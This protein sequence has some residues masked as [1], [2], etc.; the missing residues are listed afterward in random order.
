[1]DDERHGR[2]T[3]REL[4][5]A[6][7]AGAGA[8]GVSGLLADPLVAAALAAAPRCGRLSD[9]EH[10]VILVQENR[11]FDH[12]FGSYRGVAGFQDP[13]A[14]P[15]VF[16][17][18]GYPVA[19]YGGVLQPFH[20][21]SKNGGECTNDINHSWGPQHTYWD[22]GRLDGFV[23]GHVAVDGVATGAL[24]MGY[25]TRADLEFYYALADAF[26][27]CDHYHCSVI[28]PTDPN[29]LYTMSAS[30]GADGTSGGP[31]LSTS[32][33]RLER[34][35]KLSWTTMPEQLEARGVSW[36]VYSTPDGNFGDN[37]LP[38]FKQYQANG[39]LA[40]K[41]LLPS[42][43]GTFELDCL[44]GRLPQVSWVLAPLLLSEHPPTP[45]EWGQYASAQVLKAL[46]GNPSVWAKTAL[47]I[48]FDENGG[49]FDHVPPPAAPAG[50]PGEYLTVSPLPT[51]ASGVAG[52]IGLG[53][54][55]PMLIASPFARGGLVCSDIF[56]HTSTLRFL[57]SRFGTEV[58]NLSAW[59]R[60]VTGDLT[61]AFNFAAVDRSVPS[62][63][64][65]SLADPRVV[66]AACLVGAPAG[67][68]E[69][70][71]ATLGQV[72]GSLAPAYPIPP[73]GGI[74][75]QEPGTAPAPS[76]PV[77]GCRAGARSPRRA[78]R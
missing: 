19:G 35:G 37:V 38:Y 73:N 12:Y 5:R 25:Y 69:D 32:T 27:I 42:F 1:M 36:K 58:P 72:V 29:R 2:L 28:G 50:T 26:T 74:P 31:I 39:T 55:V 66:S 17:Q 64:K 68:L 41:A 15:A 60:S 20:I 40:A 75:H 34:F 71:D 57:E 7:G 61:S 24:A 8:L 56:D 76:G 70:V 53:F 13:Q 43:P 23:S 59:R 45:I 30:L 22:D 49:F 16:S 10:V 3:R 4:I 46:T 6:A 62:L 48:T 63:P 54:R 33:T 77:T 78:S 51:D 47:F 67:L 65:P 9:I 14:P 21:D 18:Q 11:S 44:L 52:P